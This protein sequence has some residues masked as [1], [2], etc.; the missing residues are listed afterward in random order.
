MRV[1]SVWWRNRLTIRSLNFKKLNMHIDILHFMMFTA[2]GAKLL[3][4]DTF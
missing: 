1:K 4:G 2:A 3:T